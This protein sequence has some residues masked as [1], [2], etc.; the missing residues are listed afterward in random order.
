[1]TGER[2]LVK[3]PHVHIVALL[4]SLSGK[5]EMKTETERGAGLVKKHTCILLRNR[6]RAL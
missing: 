4:L 3:L 2:L 5:K 6:T 1:M